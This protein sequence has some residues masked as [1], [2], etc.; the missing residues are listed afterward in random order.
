MA[1]AYL[2]TGDPENAKI[3]FLKVVESKALNCKALLNLW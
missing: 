2:T 3:Y 1:R